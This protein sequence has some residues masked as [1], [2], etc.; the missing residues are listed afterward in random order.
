[1]GVLYKIELLGNPWH[2]LVRDIS[3]SVHQIYHSAR[4]AIITDCILKTEDGGADH[5]LWVF[6]FF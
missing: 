5:P 1:M 2:E 6:F 4:L 3:P